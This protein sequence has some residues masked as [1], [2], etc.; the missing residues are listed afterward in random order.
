LGLC[1]RLVSARAVRQVRT[2]PPTNPFTSRYDS[3]C[4]C[5]M[6]GFNDYVC[7]K[8]ARPGRMPISE[9]NPETT[10]PR[11]DGC[12]HIDIDRSIDRYRY[13]CI[14]MGAV[15][16]ANLGCVV[17]SKHARSDQSSPHHDYYRYIDQSIDNYR[18]AD[19]HIYRGLYS[20]L[21]RARGVEQVLTDQPTYRLDEYIDIDINRSI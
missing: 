12:M 8:L 14:Y 21:F 4:N 20:R 2:D 19:K 16:Q 3:L 6:I 15:Q 10:F 7:S 17:S 1:S 11:F 9:P 18:Y 13:T 5:F